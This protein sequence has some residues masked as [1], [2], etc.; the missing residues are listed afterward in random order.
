MR[1]TKIRKREKDEWNIR[2]NFWQPFLGN[3]N[4]ILANLPYLAR[5][6]SQVIHRGDIVYQRKRP[7][8]VVNGAIVKTRLGLVIKELIEEASIPQY[9][10]KFGQEDPRWYYQHDLHKIEREEN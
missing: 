6:G 2:P 1:Y 5:R 4:T 9:Y 10:V 3:C 8:A 7:G